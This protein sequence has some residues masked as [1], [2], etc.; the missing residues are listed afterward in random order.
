MRSSKN[1]KLVNQ[2]SLHNFLHGIMGELAKA[3]ICKRS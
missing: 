2:A 3:N 1:T